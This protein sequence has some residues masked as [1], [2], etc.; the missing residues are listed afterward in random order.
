[1]LVI[2]LF[3]PEDSLRFAKLVNSVSDTTSFEQSPIY[4]GSFKVGG[5]KTFRHPRAITYWNNLLF[6]SYDNSDI[7]EVFDDQFNVVKSYNISDGGQSTLTGITVDNDFIHIAD[8][9]NKEI[10]IYDHD[11]DIKYIFKWYPE[12]KQQIRCYGL[13]VKESVLYVTDP[14]NSNILAISL[15]DV[16]GFSEKGELLFTIEGERQ[17]LKSPT[18]II[19]TSDGRILVGDKNGGVK[20]FTC[21]GRFIYEFANNSEGRTFEPSGF[22]FDQMQSA[23][24][25]NKMK[26]QLETSKISKQGRI[27]VV[28]S[29]TARI[30]VYDALG[31]YVLTYGK[32]LEQPYGIAIDQKRRRVIVS[33]SDI[34]ALVVYKY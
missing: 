13:F 26:L 20:V 21:D 5:G 23:A 14:N 7:L 4:I 29:K 31:K 10:R 27:H 25:L 8:S 6:V 3:I 15:A 22:A 9:L 19:V 12:S 18:A 2:I 28:D 17:L 30:K 34:G 1:M 11:G 16:P 33:D 24:F 32:E